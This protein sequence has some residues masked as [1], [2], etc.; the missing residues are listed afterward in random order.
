VSEERVL[1]PRPTPRVRE[2]ASRYL[3]EIDRLM[4]GLRREFYDPSAVRPRPRAP[5]Q[6]FS[7]FLINREQG[8]WAEQLV[9]RAVNEQCTGL[10]AVR[11]G[12]ADDII[13]GQP[14]F[15]EF[16]QSYHDELEQLGKRPDLLLFGKE[17]APTVVADLS[18]T[19]A[20]EIQDVASKATAGLE[21][22]SSSFVALGRA[23][24][25][26]TSGEL[27]FTPKV[28]DV[29]VIHRWVA[30]HDV[31]HYFV[32]VFFDSVWMLPFRALLEILQT[33]AAEGSRFSVQRDQRNQF[34]TTLHIPISEG[35]RVSTRVEEPCHRSVRH[36]F[37]DGRLAF[38]VRFSGG[39][40]QLDNEAFLRVLGRL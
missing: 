6:A 15:K 1:F 30:N 10:V 21:I 11:Y 19:P 33:P 35:T 25:G 3:T 7:Q 38:Y 22:R 26:A 2:G 36:A 13:A 31:P 39:S 14:G 12:R 27:S 5:T 8:D 23:T 24:A 20:R 18:R 17:V 16:F 9:R 4:G 34:K 40:L 32:Q 37:A 28:E 29:Y